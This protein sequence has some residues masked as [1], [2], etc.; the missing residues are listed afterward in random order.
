MKADTPPRARAGGRAARRA[1]RTAPNFEMLPGLTHNLPICEVM[2]SAQV[3]RIDMASMD[4]LE[5]VGIQFRDPIALADWK[6]A[7]ANVD[8][9]MVYLDRGL[10]RELIKTIPSEFTYH[11]RD[12][13]NMWTKDGEIQKERLVLVTRDESLSELAL[14]ND[15]VL[16]L[17]GPL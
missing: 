2:D 17:F 4:I 8:G 1:I 11:A 9:E 3:E 16:K 5:N 7:G 14:Q 6:G 12:H 10:V 15:A 13:W